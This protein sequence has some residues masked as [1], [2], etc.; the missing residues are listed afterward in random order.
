LY[1]DPRPKTNKEDLFNRKDELKQ[2]QDVISYASVIVVT[3][4]RRTGKT[5]FVD[6]ALSETKHPQIFLDMRDLPVNPSRAELIRK[7]EAAFNKV[8]KEWLSALKDALKHVKGISLAGNSVAFDWGEKGVD[9]AELF[10]R[11]DAWAKNHK[12]CFLLALDEVQ[13]IRGDKTIPKLFARIADV[14]R[15]IVVIV[16]GSEIG[17]LYDFL[18]FDN[19]DSPLYGRHYVEIRM[20]NF[21]QE[22]AA[23]FLKAGLKQTRISCSKEVIEYAVKKLDGIVG[24]LTLFGA[25]CRDKKKCSKEIV[26]EVLDEGGKLARA[27]ALKIVKFSSRYGVILNFLSKV[28]E[29][30]WAKTKAALEAREKRTLPNSTFTDLLN[31]LVKTSLVEKREG[32]YFI[33]DPLLVHG[34][35]K[36]PFKE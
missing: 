30:T 26:D 3:G 27:E 9:L 23:N 28:E 34:I 36:E 16:T 18:G 2:F 14:N 17:L 7:V 35:Q 4:L 22:E 13:L 10:D 25:K 29:A 24:W 33:S 21:A 8:G 6:V 32:E 19:P 12:E 1:F 11:I 31:K 20:H 15:N 5:S